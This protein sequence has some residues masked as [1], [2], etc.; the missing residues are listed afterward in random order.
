MRI[1][2]SGPKVFRQLVAGWLL[3]SLGAW[4]GSAAP[5]GARNLEPEPA[6]EAQPLDIGDW[7]SGE[8]G[9]DERLFGAWRGG[10]LGTLTIQPGPVGGNLCFVEMDRRI[11]PAFQLAADGNQYLVIGSRAGEDLSL[12]P[13]VFRYRLDEEQSML[14]LEQLVAG[15]RRPAFDGA[16][17]LVRYLE[18]GGGYSF[19][20]SERLR[21]IHGA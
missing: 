10:S 19:E 9:V 11:I 3:V 18:Q 8:I 13:R 12:E 1:S 16:A 6:A 4:V 5:G 15:E 14:M 2:F 20:D 17:E 7:I 21:R